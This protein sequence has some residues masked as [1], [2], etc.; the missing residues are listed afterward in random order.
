MIEEVLANVEDVN[1]ELKNNERL[2]E[3]LKAELK[4]INL[5]EQIRNNTDDE[6]IKDLFE[7][8]IEEE[9][10]H[11]SEFYHMLNLKDDVQ[12]DKHEA[13]IDEVRD[14]I[15]KNTAKRPKKGRGWHNER[16]KHKL[17]ANG[18]KTVAN[19]KKK[20]RG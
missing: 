8:I 18:I 9:K 16:M 11:V 13:G 2:R 5:Y 12:F 4:A 20:G 19:R 17:A 1:E 10:H 6:D 7:H 14:I 15:G 3:A